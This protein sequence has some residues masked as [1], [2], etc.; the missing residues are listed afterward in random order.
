MNAESTACLFACLF[1]FCLQLLLARWIASAKA[2]AK[3]VFG[4]L[5]ATIYV[6]YFARNVGMK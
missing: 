3:T 2:R 6:E 1:V 5:Q 4:H